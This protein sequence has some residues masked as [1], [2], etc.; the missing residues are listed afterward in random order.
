M[1]LY[2]L[3]IDLLLTKQYLSSDANNGV[4]DHPSVVFLLTCNKL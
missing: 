2:Q 4:C 3:G 1:D